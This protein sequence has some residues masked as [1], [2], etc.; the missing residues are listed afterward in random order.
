MISAKTKDQ[1][2]IMQEGGQKLASV[3]DKLVSRI[4]PG[5][6]LEQLDQ[7]ALEFIKKEG[8]QASFAMVPGYRWATCINVNE[9]VVHGIPDNTKIRE[10]DVVSIDVG[11]YY[12]GFH[13]DTSTTVAV[14]PV[15]KEVQKLITVG[16]QALSLSI[17]KAKPGAYLA[18][19]STTMQNILE[20]EGFSPVRALTGHGIGKNLHEEPQI[21]CFWEGDIKKSPL[22]P[23]GAVL[24][25]EVIYAAGS[26]EVVLSNKD[27][28]TIR[29]E[30][31]KM[32]GLF[33]ETVAVTKNGPLVLTS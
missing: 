10:G 28:W 19:V 7:A 15:S 17:K 24:A 23:E 6:S 11:M 2:K 26:P 8:G 25:L 20:K 22:L 31:G 21:P 14:P 4:G 33:E 18:E 3:R 5:V 9:G 29:T 32:A 12:K 13:T 16:K 1:I 27:G 30:D